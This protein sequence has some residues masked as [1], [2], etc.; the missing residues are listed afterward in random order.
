MLLADYM[1]QSGYVGWYVGFVI[2]AVV[3]V[4]VV[5]LVSL[6]MKFAHK[7]A[8]QAEDIAVSLADSQA[9]TTILS[10]IPKLNS[11][12]L[13]INRRAAAARE[14]ATAKVLALGLVKESDL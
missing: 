12:V 13:T 14:A 11:T 3:I 4:I 5:A 9:N 7:I 10:A 8:E 1:S 2:S 6:I